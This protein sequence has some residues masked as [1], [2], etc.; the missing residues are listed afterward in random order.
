MTSIMS[1]SHAK[2][3]AAV[4]A[5]VWLTTAPAYAQL[6]PL[7]YLKR[8][9]PN[10]IIMVDSGVDMQ[11]DAPSDPSCVPGAANAANCTL[12]VANATSSY[13]DS[14]IYSKTGA[15]WEAKIGVTAATTTSNYRRKYSALTPTSGA[16]PF[17]ATTIST[18]G[19]APANATAYQMFEAP[20]RMSVARAAIYRA[21]VENQ[22]LVRFG[23][24]T[25]RQNNPQLATQGNITPVV[26]ADATQTTP[27]ETGTNNQ[28]KLS[29]PT[30][31]GT[32]GSF[33][34]GW[35]G[36]NSEVC[37][38]C[39]ADDPG[40]TTNAL[41]VL[42]K[43]TRTAGGLLPAGQDVLYN[44]STHVWGWW[45]DR[46]VQSMLDDLQAEAL[47][48]SFTDLFQSQCRNTVAV[49]ITSGGE[50]NTTP[51]ADPESRALGFLT[52]FTGRRVPIIVV[53]IAP[54]ASD[55]ASL[56]NIA[57]NSGGQY[58]EITKAMIDTAVASAIQT[59]TAMGL[60]ASMAGTIVVPE[61]VKAVNLGIQTAFQDFDDINN[62]PFWGGFWHGWRGY[63]GSDK[64]KSSEFQIGSPIVGTVNLTN[65]KDITGAVL[66]LTSVND[67]AGN[68]I[69]QRSNLMVTTAFVLPGFEAML[70]AFRVYKP[71]VDATQ[72][73]GYKFSADG[74]ALWIAGIPQNADGTSA[75]NKRNLYTALADGTMVAFT[76]ANANALA[77]LMNL[78]ATDA[79]TV[80]NAIRATNIGPVVDSTPA[81]QGPPS[82]DPPPDDS[83]PAFAVANAKRR[84]LL[85]VGTNYGILEAIDARLGQEVWGFI[86][87]NLLP[88]LRTVRDGQPI[89]NFSYMMD[90]S[91]KVSD[92]KLADGTWHTYLFAGEGPG[93]VFYQTFDVTMAGLASA[94]QPDDDNINDVLAYF[95]TGSAITFKWSFPSY[96]TFEP[97][98]ANV[99][100]L[101]ANI[102]ATSPWGDLKSSAPA[103]A[104]TV[105]QTWSDPAI[106]QVQDNNSP[107]VML[108]GSGFFP[109]TTQQQANR[110]G[111]VAGT[112]FYVF[113]AETGAL[114]DKRDVGSDNV[115]ETVDNCVAVNN[116]N[117]F[118][119]AIQSDPVATGPSDSRF[120][121]KAYVGTLD[122]TV[123]RFDIALN[124]SHVPTLTGNPTVLWT[125]PV[126]QP[127]F[128][129]MATVNVGGTQQYVFIGTGNDLLPSNGVSTQYRLIGLLDTG[130]TATK[131][132][133][134]DLTKVDGVAGDEK[135]TTFPAVA[136]DIVFFTTSTF[137]PASP[138]TPPSASL[139][140]LTFN[141]GPAYDT[142]N[143]GKFDSN[144]K[145]LVKTIAGER[146][147][148]PFIVDQHL[149]FGT[150][151]QVQMFGDPNDFNNGVGQA[152]VRVLSWR[153][154]R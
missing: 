134:Y 49:L 118:K 35:W 116:C 60:P 37:A 9:Q 8:S 106:G 154:V 67:K 56:Q 108:A 89:G 87:T 66:P 51:G 138:C 1:A 24:Y 86:P 111:I 59:G 122:G 133:E 76:A 135:V 131:T 52:A 119:N 33:N 3:I 5:G 71:V 58:I 20:T 143:D 92:V 18:V 103:A 63:Q 50:G 148:A 96:S 115:S 139:Y 93:G 29:M 39:S 152:G 68:P 127:I 88:M 91:P 53:A 132:F 41:G 79:T 23:L 61:A 48:L 100:T 147:T 72:P 142:N 124:S 84:T 2:R 13:Y 141:G 22:G 137:S 80:I 121:T 69:P 74:T 38:N 83:Y 144:D 34:R 64:I 101:T 46:P 26:D 105:G 78:N 10:V 4:A 107:Y 15:A 113:N 57:S 82:L 125:D 95:G 16:S 98:C 43:D 102:C 149:M 109:Y 117:T 6:D 11:R 44:G 28:W 27:T 36:T 47:R 104:K 99:A 81:M 12:T 70:R 97:N 140:A 73:S 129:S 123:T 145:P 136:G 153:E 54:P 128:G 7:A 90:G 17:S 150:G 45:R 126:K 30:V 110:G 40:S 114:L 94:V 85:W 14:Y 151:D 146:A 112:N 75:P 77:P 25:M 120:I 19:D 21:I 130:T 32:N 62:K 31:S 55:R 65:A 42:A